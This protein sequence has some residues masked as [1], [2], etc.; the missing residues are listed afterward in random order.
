MEPSP[1]P[2]RAEQFSERE[3]DKYYALLPEH[4]RQQGGVTRFEFG[5]RLNRRRVDK[6]GNLIG[7]SLSDAVETHDIWTFSRD[8]SSADPNWLLDETDEA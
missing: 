2:L 4:M 3:I 1:C 8:L 5:R 7:G 6:D